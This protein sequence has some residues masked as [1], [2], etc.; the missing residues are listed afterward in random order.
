[1]VATGDQIPEITGEKWVAAAMATVEVG[2]WVAV[3]MVMKDLMVVQT[4]VVTGRMMMKIMI[5]IHQAPEEGVQLV[6]VIQIPVVEIQVPATVPLL[7]E[8]AEVR[9]S[10]LHH[11]VEV[12]EVRVQLLEDPAQDQ[13]NLAARAVLQEDPGQHLKINDLLK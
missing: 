1:M 3:D 9:I 5:A 2:E 12:A 4:A 10:H 11:P 8:E 6:P 7:W 13:K